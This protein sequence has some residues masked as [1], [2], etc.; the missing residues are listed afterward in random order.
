MPTRMNLATSGAT[1]TAEEV[2]GVLIQPLVARSRVMA[3]ARAAR[4]L[5][6]SNGVPLSLPRLEA[7]SVPTPWKGEGEQIAEAEATIGAATMLPSTLKS[8]K[9][10]HRTSRELL[11]HA[12]LPYSEDRLSGEEATDDDATAE[13]LTDAL[14]LAVARTMD[15]AFL[16]GDGAPTGTTPV[17]LANRT[18]IQVMTGVG[19]PT[20]DHLM[21]AEGLLLDNDDDNLTNFVWYMRGRTFTKLRKQRAGGDGT[22]GYLM[23][24]DPTQPGQFTLLG[25]PVALTNQIPAN[26]GAGANETLMLLVDMAQVAVA[27]DVYPE[28]TILDQVYALTD[29]VGIRVV[30]RADL[31]EL[32][33]RAIVKLA[34]VL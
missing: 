10:I 16:V 28:V 3:A 24:P 31:S 4:R 5:F 12:V 33:A 15:K 25:H 20:V 32:N 27:V 23:Q 11:R 2:A 29:E 14:V 26:L 30:M 19:A 9:T 1:L 21:D 13:T 18:G 6:Q 34:G 22:G 17:G 8:V 7:V